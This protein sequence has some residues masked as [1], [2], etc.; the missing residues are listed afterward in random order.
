VDILLVVD[1]SNSM[2]PE[3]TRLAQK[4]QGFVNDLTNS[5][6]DWQMCSTVTRAQ[7]VNNV[8]YWGASKNWVG[9]VGSPAWILKL[10]ATDPYSIFTNT[11]NQIG[12]G[13]AGT[14][15]ERAI[16][17]AIAHADYSTYNTCYRNDA[18]LAVIILSD[19][20]ERSIGGNMALQYYYAEWK[21][22][23]AD[24]YPQAFVNKIKQRFGP[25]K[26]VSVN[27]IIVKPGDATCMASQDAGGAKS[28]YG[29]KYKELSNLTQG[30]VG[31]ICDAD[32]SQSL[33]YFKDKIKQSL[34][35]I[36]LECAPVGAVSVAITPAMGGVTSQVVNNTLNFSPAIPAG[37]TVTIEY[38]CAV[39]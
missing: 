2:L 35:S 6:L 16:K 5:G 34:S 38:D 23:E 24:D 3:N 11:I 27:S 13:W 26:P 18:S 8:L 39:N 10:G 25:K 31:S 9:Y 32:Y 21:A 28:H 14:D 17:A 7:T 22:L 1:D 20:D 4:L 36:P 12:A 15:D 19:E 30:Y 33:Y 37:R 29:Y